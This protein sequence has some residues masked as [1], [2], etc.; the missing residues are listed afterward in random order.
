MAGETTKRNNVISVEVLTVAICVGSSSTPLY[1]N[2][3]CTLPCSV[4]LFFIIII[5]FEI[6]GV[7]CKLCESSSRFGGMKMPPRAVCTSTHFALVVI[8]LWTADDDPTLF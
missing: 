5:L 7:K 3:T 1:W 2:M 4:R 8:H 6:K